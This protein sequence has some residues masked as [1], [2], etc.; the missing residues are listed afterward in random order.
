MATHAANRTNAT[1]R[2]LFMQLPKG[3]RL[4][5]ENQG[6]RQ[7][8]CLLEAPKKVGAHFDIVPPTRNLILTSRWGSLQEGYA[9]PLITER[10]Q[11]AVVYDKSA[12]DQKRK[13][14]PR[15]QVVWIASE[16]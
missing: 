5:F 16:S 11:S 1:E 15:A 13:F 10:G 12:S 6:A 14:S 2:Y 8:D 4:P 7:C 3:S 9:N